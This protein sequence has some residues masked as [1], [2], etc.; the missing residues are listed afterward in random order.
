MK[1]KL[2]TP[3]SVHLQM[4]CNKKGQPLAVLMSMLSLW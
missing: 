2:L 1:N 3:S 4:N